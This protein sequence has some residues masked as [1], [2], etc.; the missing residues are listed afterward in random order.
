MA[1][2]YYKDFRILYPRPSVQVEKG[3]RTASAFFPFLVVRKG[4]P[5]PDLKGLYNEPK[6][7]VEKVGESADLYRLRLMWVKE[8]GHWLVKQASL[9]RF[10]GLYFSQ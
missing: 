2:N 6:R 9:E 10:T 3:G 1:F 5:I 8:A 4:N 7:W